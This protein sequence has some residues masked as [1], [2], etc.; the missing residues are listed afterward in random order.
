METETKSPFISLFD[1][2]KDYVDTRLNL[3]KLKAI[4]KSSGFLS[5]LLTIIIVILVGFVCF[6]MLNIGLALLIGKWLGE[7]YLGFLIVAALYII[8][9]FVIYKFRNKWLK[10]PIASM[11]IK[12]LLD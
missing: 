10:G 3:L 2:L 6:I 9:G 1:K 11:M 8:I 12:S 7:Y 5:S 4:D